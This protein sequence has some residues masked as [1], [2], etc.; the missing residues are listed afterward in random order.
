MKRVK[1]IVIILVGVIL[2]YYGYL[3]IKLF[4]QTDS[5]LDHGCSWNYEKEK[6]DCSN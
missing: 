6:C 3:K 4:I 1:V 2:L 5:C